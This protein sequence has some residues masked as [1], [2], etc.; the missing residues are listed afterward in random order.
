[1]STIRTLR[2]QRSERIARLLSDNK[3]LFTYVQP[4]QCRA[5]RWGAGAGGQLCFGSAD[6]TDMPMCSSN[7]VELSIT[8]RTKATAVVPGDAYCKGT[9][10]NKVMSFSNILSKE[11]HNK[12]KYMEVSMY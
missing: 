12:N 5:G 8:I 3:H 6:T 1:M 4:D 9:C 10:N 7:D 11:R 2:T